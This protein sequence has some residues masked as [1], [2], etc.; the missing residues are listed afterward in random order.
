MERS[1]PTTH[2]PFTI[3]G[4]LLLNNCQ[5]SMFTKGTPM[6]YTSASIRLTCLP[7][8]L[9]RRGWLKPILTPVETQIPGW[10]KVPEPVQQVGNG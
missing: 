2:E 6:D 3:A 9:I 5:A 4:F 1:S 7:D 10:L 8:N